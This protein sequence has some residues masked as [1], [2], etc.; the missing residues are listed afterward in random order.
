MNTTK[1]SRNG[2]RSSKKE[3]GLSYKKAGLIVKVKWEDAYAESRW[4]HDPMEH[5]PFIVEEVGHVIFHDKRGIMLAGSRG[6]NDLAG[7]RKFIPAGMIRKIKV[8]K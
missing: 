6:Y 5:E 8:L 4:S 3:R 1:R 7:S 2:F